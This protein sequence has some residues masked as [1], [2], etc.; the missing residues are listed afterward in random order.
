M[1]W[2]R[3]PLTSENNPSI[4]G[5]RS[6]PERPQSMAAHHSQKRAAFPG[7]EVGPVN[8]LSFRHLGS[9]AAIR[10]YDLM[11]HPRGQ[12]G[13]RERYRYRQVKKLRA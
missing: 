8:G 9:G 3:A 1:E 7:L 4:A 2:R 10:R 12:M 6:G 11:T 5:A 13:P